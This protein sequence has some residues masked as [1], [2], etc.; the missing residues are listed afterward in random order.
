M[1]GSQRKGLGKMPRKIMLWRHVMRAERLVTRGS[2]DS[3]RP[4]WVLYA[5]CG[6][7][8]IVCAPEPPERIAC[9][10]CLPGGYQ[11]ALPLDLPL[12]TQYGKVTMHGPRAA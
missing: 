9:E 11:L 2:D 12:Q 10:H 4:A 6:H 3:P 7:G 8:R 5:E 1:D